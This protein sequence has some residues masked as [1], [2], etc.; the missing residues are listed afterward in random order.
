[1]TWYALYSP[2]SRRAFNNIKLILICYSGFHLLIIYTYQIQMM[3]DYLDPSTLIARLLG[4]TDLARSAGCDHW[5]DFTFKSSWTAYTHY[6]SLWVYFFC[7]VTQYNWT[8]TGIR[9]FSDRGQD[10][11]SSDHEEVSF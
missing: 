9:N 11:A 10:D 2:I 4:L 3:K 5:W 7:A 8:H 1:M 6:F